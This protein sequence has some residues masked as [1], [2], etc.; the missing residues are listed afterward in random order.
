MQ[1]Q[2]ATFTPSDLEAVPAVNAL[3]GRL[4]LGRL[5]TEDV[6][7]LF[8][9]NENWAGT[10]SAGVGVFVK[11]VSLDGGPEDAALRIARSRSFA[12][13]IA[14]HGSPDLHTPE[15]I[16]E[17]A[18]SQVL[19]FRLL[20]ETRTFA[21]LSADEELDAALARRAGRAVGVLHGL[22]EALDGTTHA[23]GLDR[24]SFP[25]PSLGLL[26][27]LPLSGFM[28]LTFAEVTLWR[29][30]H[31][32]PELTEALAALRRSEAAAP[33]VTAHCDL[34]FDQFLLSH[35]TLH[36]TDGEEFRW[37]DAARDIGSLAGEWL[38]R[39][40]TGLTSPGRDAPPAALVVRE[41]THEE[42]VARG[43]AEMDRVRPLISAFW[44]GYRSTRTTADSQLATRATA[45]AGWHMID[46]AMATAG[47][48]S[49]LPAVTRAAMGVG[50]TA[51]LA[52]QNFVGA[53]GLEAGR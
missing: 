28:N 42:I 3:L 13:M 27:A 24:S 20:D 37:A 43:V 29:I 9:R 52:P 10:T 19:V 16:G 21:E 26:R 41:A 34:R 38:F 6:E 50:R 22:G 17:D 15:L 7:S 48:G 32:D 51:L 8:G 31:G 18:T 49:R 14:A 36:L 35:G 33:Q 12:T 40:I 11:R 4:G 2:R 47:R 25:F 45:F 39:A 5:A 46:R 30:L 44:A 23:D 53:L 1:G